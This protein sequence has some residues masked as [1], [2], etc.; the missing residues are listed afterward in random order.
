MRINKRG[1]VTIP[2]HLRDGFG[3]HHNIEV[4][5]TPTEHGILIQKQPDGQ[6]PVERIYGILKTNKNTDD[7]I[8]EIK[9]R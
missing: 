2:K 4:V 6:H 1:Q 7:Y 8:S 3:M 9:A 5:L